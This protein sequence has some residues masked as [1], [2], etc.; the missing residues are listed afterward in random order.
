MLC[1]IYTILY[2]H[3]FCLLTSAVKQKLNVLKPHFVILVLLQIGWTGWK[4]ADLSGQS[5]VSL[6]R[7]L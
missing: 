7:R 6:L 3:W 1:L 5:G 4:V 2:L